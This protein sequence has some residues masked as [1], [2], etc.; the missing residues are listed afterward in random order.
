MQPIINPALFYLIDLSKGL[1]FFFGIIGGFTL[2]VV[3]IV[4]LLVMCEDGYDTEDK[5]VMETWKRIKY[6]LIV[7]LACIFMTVIIPSEE[8]CYKMVAANI[9]TPNNIEAVGDTATDIID[10]IVDSVEEI[11]DGKED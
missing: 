6:F 1:S 5:D 3:F 2:A 9:V 8:T 11:I 7:G 4:G 10:Y